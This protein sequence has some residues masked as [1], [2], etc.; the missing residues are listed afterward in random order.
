M[1]LDLSP[2]LTL[3]FP[4]L[5]SSHPLSP[6]LFSF[7]QNEKALIAVGN[8]SEWVQN[9]RLLLNVTEVTTLTLP[10]TLTKLKI[11]KTL[12][13]PRECQVNFFHMRRETILAKLGAQPAATLPSVKVLRL[14][15][16]DFRSL[17]DVDFVHQVRCSA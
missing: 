2:S 10:R 8:S 16:N 13:L 15:N 3:F 11:K 17:Q 14:V 6:L 9:K 4:L 1:L 12:T 7:F 5:F